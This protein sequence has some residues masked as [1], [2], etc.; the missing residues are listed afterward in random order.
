LF[1]TRI[2]GYIGWE[3]AA[4]RL[5]PT[6]RDAAHFDLTEML[7]SAEVRTT[8][9]AIDYLAFRMLRVPI[10]PAMRAALI[11]FLDRELGTASLDRAG[12]YMEDP[13]RMTVHLLMSTPEYQIV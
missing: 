13:L 1:N 2:S 8:A 5:I 3:Q 12:T 10:S 6:P 11:E 9:E 7:A 4:R